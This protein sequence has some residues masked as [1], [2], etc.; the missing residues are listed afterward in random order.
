MAVLF[1][2]ESRCGDG[3]YSTKNKNQYESTLSTFLG[4]SNLYPDKLHPSP[5]WDK[6]M[7]K[8][9]SMLD[10]SSMYYFGFSSIKQLRSWLSDEQLRRIE[11]YHD[12]K[13]GYRIVMYNSDD[14]IIGKTQCAFIREKA[15]WLGE[16]RPSLIVNS[17]LIKPSRFDFILN[18]RLKKIF[19]QYSKHCI[20]MDMLGQLPDNFEKWIRS[21]YV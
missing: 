9:W 16:V 6:K 8:K 10:D 15:T 20:L 12:D 17:R 5:L 18:K 19:T 1:R 2:I 3:L 7:S 13:K 21:Y 14:Y 11:D 4:L